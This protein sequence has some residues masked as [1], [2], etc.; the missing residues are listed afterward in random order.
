MSTWGGRVGESGVADGLDVA[1]GGEEAGVAPQC[2]S[3]YNSSKKPLITAPSDRSDKSVSSADDDDS[4][5]AGRPM[6]AD[7][8]DVA[9]AAPDAQL[10]DDG[11]SAG[12]AVERHDASGAGERDGEAESAMETPHV[13]PVHGPAP[14]PGGDGQP[15]AGGRRR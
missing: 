4:M 3:M 11:G 13:F 8:P 1:P 12:G 10:D 14:S 5:P 15:T 2:D 7:A 9:A 6:A